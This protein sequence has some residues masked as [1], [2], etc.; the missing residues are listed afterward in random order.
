MPTD[1][2]NIIF[3][4]I[5]DNLSTLINGE[6]NVPVYYN[7]HKGNQSFLVTPESDSLVTKL[8]TGAQREY[9]VLISYELKS[10]GE[11]TK[12]NLKQVSNT[13]ERL[14]KLIYNNSSYSNGSEWFDANITDIEYL[15]DEDDSS[16]LRGVGTFNCQNIE[17][18]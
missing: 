12:N 1:F 10:G 4:K 17:V 13:M 3:D 6:F 15:R 18:F 2:T 11:Y 9:T 8:S 5:I 7:E 14:K 16:L